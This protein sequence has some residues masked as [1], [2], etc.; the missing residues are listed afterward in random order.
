MHRMQIARLV[1]VLA[2]RMAQ[3]G[4][5]A[6]EHAGSDVAVAPDHVKQFLARAHP[7]RMLDELQQR[8]ER[9]RFQ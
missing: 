9:F 2:E 1:A 6:A 5:D 4:D 7:P 8:I 3:Q